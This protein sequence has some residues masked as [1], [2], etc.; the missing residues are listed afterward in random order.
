MDYRQDD[1]RLYG[2]EAETRYLFS[3]GPRPWQ[4]RLYGDT[5]RGQIDG[6][7][8]L[9]RITPT[10]L[11]VG[12]SGGYG[13]WYGGVDLSQILDQNRISPLETETPGY[14]LLS[15]DIEYNLPGRWPTSL[16]LRGRNLLDEDARRHTS[17]LKDV[18]PLP[19]ASVLLGLRAELDL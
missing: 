16:Y 17:F 12:F 8:N 18:A 13:R 3:S 1:A 14:T 11:G 2:L 19:G 7:P 6:G 15:A 4:L 9:P 5:V 10:R